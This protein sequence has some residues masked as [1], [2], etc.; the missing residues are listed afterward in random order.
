MI[1]D[2]KKDS[3]EAI[4]MIW[5]LEEF[6]YTI[7]FC[8]TNFLPVYIQTHLNGD[9]SKLSIHLFLVW[10]I[11]LSRIESC[12]TFNSNFLQEVFNL[13]VLL[14]LGYITVL[15]ECIFRATL[16][17]LSTNTIYASPVVKCFLRRTL[18]L[19]WTLVWA[20]LRNRHEIHLF[21]PSD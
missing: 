1:F 15:A 16:S 6:H 12:C 20:I 7:L 5:F 9:W 4:P 17:V 8:L 11:N 19:N 2:L 10:V 3:L 14:P 18:L 21:R 13:T